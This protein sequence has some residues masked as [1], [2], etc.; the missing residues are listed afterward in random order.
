MSQTQLRS[1][2]RRYRKL[3]LRINRSMRQYAIWDVD[4]ENGKSVVFWCCAVLR[5][6]PSSTVIA[7]P[8]LLCGCCDD[9]CLLWFARARR[10]LRWLLLLVLLRLRSL[11]LTRA[12]RGLRRPNCR[13]THCGF[14]TGAKRR[15][16]RGVTCVL[17]CRAVW[18]EVLTIC[19]GVVFW[20]RYCEL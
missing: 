7:T 9:C 2:T 16:G 17:Q 6:R 3:K 10:K 12:Q 18:E 19:M 13:K 20:C 11:L 1:P 5:A 15:R 8:S 14:R 4:W